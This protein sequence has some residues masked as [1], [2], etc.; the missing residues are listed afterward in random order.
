M[1]ARPR[2]PMSQPPLPQSDGRPT[3]SLNL[4]PELHGQGQHI[5]HVDD[6]PTVT[7]SVRRLLEKLGYI[8][9]SFNSPLAALEHF[10]T[11]P[12]R[13]HLVLTDLMMPDMN[14]L[15]FTAAVLALRPGLPVVLFS[16]FGDGCSAS[17]I[18]RCGIR[19]VILKPAGLI[20]IAETIRRALDSHSP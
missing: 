5:L 6:E 20:P 2:C 4:R 18:Q 8:V 12:Q 16:A 9:A 19:E 13:F 1:A 10:R 3:T 17:D 7:L 15:Q 11:D 14:G